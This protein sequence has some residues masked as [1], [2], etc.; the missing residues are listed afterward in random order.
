MSRAK[1]ARI[2][3]ARRVPALASRLQEDLVLFTSWRGRY[4]DS[5]RAIAEELRRRRAPLRQVWVLDPG[6]PAVPDAR[7]V[8]FDSRAFLTD[9]GRAGYVVSNNTMPDYFRKKAG[10][11]YVQTWHGTPLKRIAFD[12]PNPS[13]KR[14]SRILR[15][16]ERDV[17][18]WDVLVSPNRFSTEILRKAFRYRGEIAETGYP[19]TDLLHA[20]DREATRA[21]LRERLGIADGTRAVL[22]APTWR[23]DG[24]FS[25]QLDLPLMARALGDDH[26]VLVRAHHLDGPLVNL[27]D[28]TCVRNVSDVPDAIDLCLAADVLV[29][30]YSSVMFDF[31]VTGKPML[32]FT[33]DLARYRDV[34]RGFYFDFEKEAPGPLLPTTSQVIDALERLDEVSAEHAEAYARFHERFC[35]LDDGQAAGRVV[36]LVF[37]AAA[38]RRA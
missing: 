25:L 26:V 3:A 11:T 16:L 8:A 2:P 4:A 18:N 38:P 14:S 1:L 32:F 34:L 28:N 37:G 19:R 33:Y 22:Y 17:S 15:N 13:F 10:S 23:D 20:A 36:D 5:P 24:G 6:T 9:L 35:H 31:A 21:S 7:A 27:R 30:D 12:I 29:T